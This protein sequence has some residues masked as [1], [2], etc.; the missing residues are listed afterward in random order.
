MDNNTAQKI[1]DNIFGEAFKEKTFLIATSSIKLLK[2]ADKILMM[3]DGE[4]KVVTDVEQFCKN[5]IQKNIDVKVSFFNEIICR[6][7]IKY[8]LNR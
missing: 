2:K 7:Q 4:I 8:K 5:L 1:A 3:Q 6:I